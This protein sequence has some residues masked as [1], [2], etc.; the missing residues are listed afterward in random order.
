MIF[1]YFIYFLIIY[2]HI[3]FCIILLPHA[4]VSLPGLGDARTYVDQSG[5]RCSVKIHYTEVRKQVK[6]V[7]EVGHLKVQDSKSYQGITLRLKDICLR[8]LKL[9][10]M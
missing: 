1:F 2:K 5:L 3:F 10:H 9:E 7:E 4:F 8:D 6:Q